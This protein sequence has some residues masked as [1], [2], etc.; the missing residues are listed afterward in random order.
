MPGTLRIRSRRWHRPRRSL[1]CARK[2]TIGP[3]GNWTGCAAGARSARRWRRGSASRIRRLPRLE[4]EIAGLAPRRVAVLVTGDPLWFSAGTRFLE[5]FP[6]GD[7]TLHPQLSAFQWAAARMGWGLADAE[8]LTVHG[9]PAEQILPLL[10]PGQR[11]LALTRDG[12]QPAEI[13]KKPAG[14]PRG[15]P[16]RLRQT[17][18][19][20]AR[21]EPER[22]PLRFVRPDLCLLPSCRH[23][24]APCQFRHDPT[25]QSAVADCDKTP[26]RLQACTA[27]RRGATLDG[28]RQNDAPRGRAR[29][30]GPRR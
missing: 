1:R 16:E 9:R 24:P 30:G 11:L 26:V 18:G 13:G 27:A 23:A 20:H 25:G 10:S 29:P 4:A 21:N 22:H 19:H 17:V 14:A 5:A 2:I 3:P 6:R 8:T 28:R 12:A 15:L 7:I